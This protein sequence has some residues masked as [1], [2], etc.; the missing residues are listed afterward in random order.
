MADSLEQ[1]VQRL[2]DLTE[3][4]QLFVDYGQALD[5]GDFATYA[6]YFA[7]DGEI[8]LGPMGRATGP[9]AIEQLM[10]RTL[11]GRVGS[12]IHII[13]SPQVTLDGDHATARVMWTVIHRDSDGRPRLTM[14]GH[15]HDELVKVKGRWL[16]QKRRGTIEMPS[17]FTSPDL[18]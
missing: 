2:E 3:I 12:S 5:T 15:H 10:R 8:L 11:D 13:S 4:H 9:A 6:G 7:D 16:F 1:R 18:A 14:V 17:A